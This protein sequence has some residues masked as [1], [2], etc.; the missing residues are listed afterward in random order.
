MKYYVN[1][2]IN[3]TIN[4]LFQYPKDGSQDSRMLPALTPITEEAALAIFSQLPEQQRIAAEKT[5]EYMVAAKAYAKLKALY[6]MS[7]S[8]IQTWTTANVTTVAQCRDAITTLAIAVSVLMR[9]V[10]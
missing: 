4:N 7:S 8:E 2:A 10:D 9:R 1:Q 5:A 6:N 3:P